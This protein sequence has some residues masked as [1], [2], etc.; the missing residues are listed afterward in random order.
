MKPVERCNDPFIFLNVEVMLVY[1]IEKG[2]L[3]LCTLPRV[4]V[5]ELGLVTS[6]LKYDIVQ[7]MFLSKTGD[8]L[9]FVPS[10]VH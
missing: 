9:C 8:C 1:A 4:L 7:H 3:M 2:E 5:L 6:K 10:C